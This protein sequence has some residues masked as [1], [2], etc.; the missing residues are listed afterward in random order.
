MINVAV[1][2]VVNLRGG[3]IVFEILV[4]LNVFFVYI[5]FIS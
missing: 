3:Y 4:K 2:L 1:S 5:D